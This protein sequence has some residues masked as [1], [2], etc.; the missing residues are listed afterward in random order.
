MDKTLLN[1]EYYRTP[2]ERELLKRMPPNTLELLALY[3]CDNN[4]LVSTSIEPSDDPKRVKIEVVRR[5]KALDSLGWTGF[6][7]SQL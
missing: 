6:E 7:S 5:P 2:V 1:R 4:P 3:L